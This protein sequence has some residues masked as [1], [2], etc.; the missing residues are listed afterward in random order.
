MKTILLAIAIMIFNISAQAQWSSKKVK[1]N[2]KVTTEERTV[3]D[4]D[5]IKVSGSFDVFLVSG[6][7]GKLTVEA[8]ENL[9]PYIITENKG[10]ALVIKNK[11][12]INLRLGRNKKIKITVPFEDIEAISL[13]GSGDVNGKDLIKAQDFRASLAGSG[14]MAIQVN[15]KCMSGSVSGSGDLTLKGSTERVK[16]QIAG[17]GDIHAKELHATHAEAHIAGSGNIKMNCNGG[18]LKVRVSGSGDVH[19]T[20]N[21]KNKDVKING[22]GNVF[23]S[24]Q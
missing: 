19:Y 11:K 15:A 18:I 17:S 20:G 16:L 7:E 5:T 12:G 10:S 9:M 14:N 24:K 2:G 23:N 13:S 6:S 8:E 22:S 1:G 4:Y 21:P 3:D